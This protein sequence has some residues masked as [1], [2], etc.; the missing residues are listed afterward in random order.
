MI[1]RALASV[2]RDFSPRIAPIHMRMMAL[3]RLSFM[4]SQRRIMRIIISTWSPKRA[5]MTGWMKMSQAREAAGPAYIIAHNR[6]MPLM[7]ITTP[8]T[9]KPWHSS[10]VI[11]RSPSMD[12]IMERIMRIRRLVLNLTAAM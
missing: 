7:N 9:L 4:M 11:L 5:T 6:R 1:G 10:S 12:L 2:A 3:M 8:K